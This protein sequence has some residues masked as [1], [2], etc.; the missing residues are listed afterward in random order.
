MVALP[1]GRP[2]KAADRTLF[3]LLTN[4]PLSFAFLCQVLHTPQPSQ[5]GRQDKTDWSGPICL[6]QQL[7]QSQFQNEWQ[8]EAQAGVPEAPCDISGLIFEHIEG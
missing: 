7:V 4:P 5:R 6:V 1:F 2:S 3:V 8:M